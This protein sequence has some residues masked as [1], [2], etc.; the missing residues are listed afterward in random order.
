MIN[1]ETNLERLIKAF[2]KC[3]AYAGGVGT[4][5]AVQFRERNRSNIVF[6]EKSGTITDADVA[7]KFPDIVATKIAAE[8]MGTSL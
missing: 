7:K 4:L 8:G 5:D 2:M 6:F 3:A 1:D